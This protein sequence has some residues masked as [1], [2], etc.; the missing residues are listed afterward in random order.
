MGAAAADGNCTEATY[1]DVE[2]EL[3]T[4]AE[5]WVNTTLGANLPRGVSG[6]SPVVISRMLIA[7]YFG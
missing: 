1:V 4:M 5:R 3:L 6:E 2:R 7:K